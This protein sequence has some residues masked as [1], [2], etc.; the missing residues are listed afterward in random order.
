MFF[1]MRKS[2]NIF[3]SSKRSYTYIHIFEGLHYKRPNI[4]DYIFS[5]QVRSWKKIINPCVC[6]DLILNWYALLTILQIFY[7]F[8]TS[9]EIAWRS[10]FPFKMIHISSFWFKNFIIDHKFFVSDSNLLVYG[11]INNSTNE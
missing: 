3:T 6:F 9:N 11:H 8:S 2:E 10:S 4:W 5:I 7:I 1:S